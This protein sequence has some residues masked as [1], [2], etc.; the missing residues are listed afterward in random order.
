MTTILTSGGP[1]L[2]DRT[3]ARRRHRPSL[4]RVPPDAEDVLR[5]PAASEAGDD[6][7]Y[8]QVRG[9][10]GLGSIV[11]ATMMLLHESTTPVQ[12]TL[13]C[14]LSGL[15]DGKPRE[16]SAWANARIS[17]VQV[18]C[19]V[20]GQAACRRPRHRRRRQGRRCL[21]LVAVRELENRRGDLVG[22]HVPSTLT[23]PG[24]RRIH[25]R[26]YAA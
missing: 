11:P 13:K 9:G 17:A 15:V 5:E 2:R 10:W 24:I 14:S 16:P 6:Y 19:R 21:A 1:V 22:R 3:G 23:R 4:A 7:D 18:R 26:W 12:V 8:N 20:V 25:L